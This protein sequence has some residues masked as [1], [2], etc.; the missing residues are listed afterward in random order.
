MTCSENAGKRKESI[1]T[2]GQPE[3]HEV[4]RSEL[5]L[6]YDLPPSP[7]LVPTLAGDLEPEAE[8]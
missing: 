5:V 4:L 2:E 1:K 3:S 6:W 7:P 8:P